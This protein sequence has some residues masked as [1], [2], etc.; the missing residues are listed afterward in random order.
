MRA[1]FAVVL[2]GAL[3]AA[4]T[5]AL[6]SVRADRTAAELRAEFET[7]ETA[8]RRL[9]TSDAVP[10]SLPGARA[11]VAFD[12]PD[13]SFST[14]RL[15]FVRIGCDAG[16]CNRPFAFRLRGGDVVSLDAPG[17]RVLTPDGPVVLR[18]GG[19]RRLRLSLVESPAGPAVAVTSGGAA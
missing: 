5:P 3:L 14:A 16:P 11:S 8:A 12:V 9:A 2:A 18:G 1:V 17:V 19:S 4:S 13:A 6:E 7:L 15:A 10:S